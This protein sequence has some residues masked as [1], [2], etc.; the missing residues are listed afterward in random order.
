MNNLL[1]GLRILDL[2]QVAAGPYTTM[3]MGYFGADVIKVK[4]NHF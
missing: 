3:L 4:G 2:T 1:N